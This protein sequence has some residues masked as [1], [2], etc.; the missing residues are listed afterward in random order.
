MY[1]LHGQITWEFLGSIKNAKFSGY[2]FYMNKK[3]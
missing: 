3:I 2:A 1:K